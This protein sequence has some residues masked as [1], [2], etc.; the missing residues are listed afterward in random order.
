MSRAFIRGLTLAVLLAAAA[1][2][3][4]I[5]QDT[6]PPE[7]PGPA[8]SPSFAVGPVYIF[9]THNT[10]LTV[11]KLDPAGSSLCSPDLSSCRRAYG[12]E[13]L[14][15]SKEMQVGQLVKWDRSGIFGLNDAEMI[16]CFLYFDGPGGAYYSC[17][18]AARPAT[19]SN[20]MLSQALT[21]HAWAVY[22]AAGLQPQAA[23]RQTAL[24]NQR[25]QTT[26]YAKA[27]GTLPPERMKALS[28]ED[29]PIP[30]APPSSEPP[31]VV[32]EWEQVTVIGTK[33]PETPPPPPAPPN[34]VILPNLTITPLQPRSPGIISDA[35]VTFQV[36]AN[37]PAPPPPVLP[38]P[39]PRICQPQCSEAHAAANAACNIG[40]VQIGTTVAIV[41]P[42]MSVVT[43]MVGTPAMGAIFFKAA[44][45]TG[46]AAV[47]AWAGACKAV[48]DSSLQQCI[49]RAKQKGC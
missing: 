13:A 26:A 38:P 30:Y 2:T 19:T 49:A 25:V 18:S 29:D 47:A 5:P 23:S 16:A 17:Q 41:V 43:S 21:A 40:A 28:T 31:P 15:R 39:P 37:P 44:G 27:Y 42:T 34:V 11:L 35:C 46:G 9:G 45:V 20:Y 1:S 12:L 14:F 32:V 3:Q 48:N 36:C 6:E 24:Y 4:A 33:S 7:E 8:P 22:S 10:R